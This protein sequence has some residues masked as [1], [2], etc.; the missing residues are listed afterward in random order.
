MYEVWRKVVK[1]IFC[2]CAVREGGRGAFLEKEEKRDAMTCC[3]KGS[4][5]YCLQC[6][7]LC[8]HLIFKR[9]WNDN[10]LPFMVKIS[11]LVGNDVNLVEGA[12]DAASGSTG[13]SRPR[14]S[15][16]SDLF[17]K[18]FLCPTTTTSSFDLLYF[19]RP[20]S[21]FTGQRLVYRKRNIVWNVHVLS[22]VRK[23]KKR[24]RFCRMATHHIEVGGGKHLW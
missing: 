24:R 6:H 2:T 10:M 9:T 3:V 14:K 20:L 13:D 5:T 21:C 4:E 8:L 16:F 19:I 7:V 11:A 18:S 1:C 22:T 12:G 23:E 15:W 17:Q